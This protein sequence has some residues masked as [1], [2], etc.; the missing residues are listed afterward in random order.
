MISRIKRKNDELASRGLAEWLK[1][2]VFQSKIGNS[3]H[4]TLPVFDSMIRR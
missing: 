4:F 1:Y 3:P 2:I